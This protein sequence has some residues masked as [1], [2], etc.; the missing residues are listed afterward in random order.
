MADRELVEDLAKIPGAHVDKLS[1]PPSLFTKFCE[2]TLFMALYAVQFL[3][4]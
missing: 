1:P 3:L 2:K 4:Y